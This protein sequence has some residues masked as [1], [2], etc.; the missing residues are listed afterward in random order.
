MTMNDSATHE[1]PAPPKEANIWVRLIPVVLTVVVF[2][3][4]FWR[5]PFDAFWQA[6]SGAR[7]LPFFALMGSFSLCFFLADSAVLTAL[8]RWF[9]GPIRYRE[10]LPVRASTYIVS[11][12]N[13]QLAQ[14]ALA[15]YLNRRFRT[16]LGEITSTVVLLI[17]LEATNLIFF[18]TVGSAAFPGGTPAVFFTL[19]A[20]VVLVW[21][22]VVGIA[23]GGFGALGRRVGGNVLLSTFRKIRLRQALAVLGLKGAVFFLSLLVHATGADV[24]RHRYTAAAA[25]G[26]P[27]HRLSGG[28][29]AGHR[30]PSGHLPGR[31]DL[32]LRR[33]RRRSR[34]AR[35]QPGGAPDVHAGQRL[36]RA[37]L[38]APGLHRSVLEKERLKSLMTESNERLAARL[39]TVEMSF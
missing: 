22:A 8:I 11:I 16:P 34:P 38:S 33:L 9:H 17:L 31:L 30:G 5:I 24:L 3:V 32:L 29:A 2:G 27:A 15:L 4:I 18:A 23:R 20:V 13:T 37:D 14:A 6:V 7:L 10:L 19:P 21:I 28:R 39:T 26:V 35:L 25:A 12:I 36:F 1:E